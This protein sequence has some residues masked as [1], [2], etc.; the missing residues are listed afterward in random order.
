M[1]LFALIEDPDWDFP[2]FKV[3]ANNDTGAARGHQAGIVIP[4]DL[5]V[6]FPGLANNTSAINPTTDSRL[7]AI[8]YNKNNYLATVS[9][10]YQFQT[11]G[12]TRTAESRLTDQLSSLRNLAVGGD[13]VIFQRSIDRLDRYKITLVKQNSPEFNL[14]QQLTLGRRWGILLNNNEP[15][16]QLSLSEAIQQQERKEVAEFSL[17]DTNITFTETRSLKVARSV[18]FRVKVVELYNS[19]CSV[20]EEA[21]ASPKGTIEIDAAHIVSRSKLG[22]DDA[23]NGISLCKRHHWA[24]DNGLFGIDNNRQVVLG[25]GVTEIES[26]R[27]LMRLEGKAILEATQNSLRAHPDAFAWH[28]ENILL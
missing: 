6:F 18:A 21:L 4:T 11:W 9:T 20:C 2:F 10:R 26:N 28:R 13:I 23:R 27:P 1:A 14:V 25:N 15:L 24:F 5:R 19:T 16:T 17:T 8:L 7:E 12:G 22:V 3:L